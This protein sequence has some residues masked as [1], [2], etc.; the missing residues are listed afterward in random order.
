MSNVQYKCPVEGCT[1]VLFAPPGG[2]SIPCLI[3]PDH[4]YVQAEEYYG[5]NFRYKED[6]EVAPDKT[7]VATPGVNRNTVS[8]KNVQVKLPEMTPDELK[9][10][11]RKQYSAVSGQPPDFRWGTE[12]LKEEITAWEV[13]HTPPPTPTGE[14]EEEATGI[15]TLETPSDAPTEPEVT[16]HD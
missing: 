12:R 13:N 3:H 16:T 5:P 15:D 10:Y 9:I 7:G 2:T 6:G 1:A 8:V 14:E 4:K 11:Y